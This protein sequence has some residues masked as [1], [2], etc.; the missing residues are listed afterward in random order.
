[1]GIK[2]EWYQKLRESGFRDIEDANGRLKT[3]NSRTKGFQ[4]REALLD[5]FLKLS[6]YLEETRDI[7]PRD[8]RVLELY[9][10]GTYI[11]IIAVQVGVSRTTV[12]DIIRKYKTVHFA[13]L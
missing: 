1:M 12:K 8:R 10:D 5:F 6:A 3:P 7:P 9:C 13:P 4:D 2:E 11:K